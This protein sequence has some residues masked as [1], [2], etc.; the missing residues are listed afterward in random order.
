MVQHGLAEKMLPA[1]VLG[2]GLACGTE[3]ARTAAGA[4]RQEG[5]GA[6]RFPRGQV[7]EAPAVVTT[8]W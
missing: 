8:L 1:R 4:C 6:P 5:S 3:S 2:R 7:P